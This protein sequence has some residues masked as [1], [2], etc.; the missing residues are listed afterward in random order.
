M[1]FLVLLACGSDTKIDRVNHAPTVA[2]TAPLA[3]SAYRQGGGIIALVGEV[4]DEHDEAQ[5]LQVSWSLDAG[6]ENDL[7]PDGAGGVT[8]EIDPAA[9]ALGEHVVRLTVFDLDGA[10]AYDEIP[11]SVGGP[12]GPPLVD[13][14]APVDGTTELVGDTI[15]FIGVASDTTTPVETLLF[16]WSS[17]LDGAL[18]NAITGG[19][20]SALVISSLSVGSHVVTLAVTDGDGEVGTDTVN[21]VIEETP[22][23]P[24]PPEPGDLIFSEFMVNPE[25]VED[26]DGEWVELYNTSGYILDIAGYAF[27][28]DGADE[29]VFDASVLVEPHGYVVLCASADPLRNG[30]VACDGWF[31]RNPAGT[32]PTDGLGHGSGVAIANNDDELELTSPAGLDIDVFDYDDTDSDPILAGVSFGLDPTL[33]DGVSNDDIGNWCVQSTVMS[34][35]VDPGTPGVVNDPC[36]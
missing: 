34:G 35:A 29:W 8:W 17:D 15:S 9:L 13:I 27:H 20:Q 2:I 16:A 26:E 28:D 11:F 14:T 31:Y 10:G 5:D 32:Q 23:E 1:V 19:G 12:L 4:A 21:V 22:E 6:A 18:P 3:A 25:A 33:L 30:G 24:E 36:F 7:P